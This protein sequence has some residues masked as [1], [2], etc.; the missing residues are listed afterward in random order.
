[1]RLE[2]KMAIVLV[3]TS[4]AAA[5]LL[6]VVYVFTAPTIAGQIEADRQKTLRELFPS[7]REFKPDTIIKNSDTSVIYLAYDSAG[8]KIG[9]VF[10]AAERGYGGPVSTMVAVNIDSTVAAIKVAS[11]SKGLKETPGSGT[12]VADSTFWLQFK[13]LKRDDV[14]LTKEG[15]QVHGI[16]AATIS[17]NAVTSGVRLGLEKYLPYLGADDTP[18]PA[19]DTVAVKVIPQSDTLNP[20]KP[21]EPDS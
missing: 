1:M 9:L 18:A 10:T 3:A 4:L 16:T 14:Y 17:S 15:G 19:P 2:I 21:S 8:A 7:A 12:R 20:R 6:G 13:G 11:P 5:A